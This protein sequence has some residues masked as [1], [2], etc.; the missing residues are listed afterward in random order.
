MAIGGAGEAPAWGRFRSFAEHALRLGYADLAA[1]AILA[2]VAA[3]GYGIAVG[4]GARVVGG[5][6]LGVLATAGV[7]AARG[8]RHE[9][10]RV[11][12]ELH[13]AEARSAAFEAAEAAL[14]QAKSAAEAA[15][16][17]KSEFLANVSHEI[18]TPMN[19]IIGMTELALDTD[20][21]T[22]QREYLDM[23]RSSADALLTVI[24]DILDF[25][26]IEAGKL[27]LCPSEF[28]L[29]RSLDETMRP[30]ALRARQK[31]LAC[32]WTIAPD[33]PPVLVADAGRLRQV[34]LNLVGNAIKFTEAGGRVAVE[35]ARF[36]CTAPPDLDDATD[37]LDLH[38]TVSDTGI[39]IA[40]EQQRLIFEAFAQA[41]GSMA[42]RYGGTGLG[43]TIASQI[44]AL[45]GGRLWVDS[46]LGRGSRFQFTIRCRRPA[47][48]PE[49][50]RELEYLRGLPVLVVDDTPINRRVLEQTLRQWSME[51]TCVADAE[52]ALAQLE[53]ARSN[54]TPY[55][56]ALLDV[57]MPEQDGFALVENIRRRPYLNGVTIM[58]LSSSDLQGAAER[59]RSLGVAA[60][61]RKPIKRSDLLD[62]LLVTLGLRNSS[63]PVNS[64]VP[65]A[66]PA[67]APPPAV[68]ARSSRPLHVLVAEDNTVNQRLACRLLE[69]QGHT[70]VLADTG[71]AAL[72]ALDRDRF[73]LILMDVQMPEMDGLEATGEIRRRERDGGRSGQAAPPNSRIPIVA[74]TAHAMKGDAER[75]LDAGM[76]AYVSKPVQPTTLFAVIERVVP[77]AADTAAPIAAHH[78]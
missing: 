70:V 61:L 26:K 19:G 72:D 73:D 27:D 62:A 32:A 64:S 74:M 3:A 6:T 14:Q 31:G 55:S 38:V 41:D 66:T 1:P 22:E 48:T 40:P 42:R 60:W 7:L 39:G 46:A 59:A 76:D 58:M 44:V 71:R 63:Y 52:S 11:A 13:R 29:A 23:V 24:N 36:T 34:L 65:A 50:P 67:A 9:G 49:V 54:G 37:G 28:T 68:P 4:G 35:V 57:Q 15:N 78:R 5:L 21:S 33:V 8:L 20:L 69:R 45:M 25:A 77:G 2:L 43:L 17:A 10:E 16:R 12:R 30:L 51:P 53:V 56:L 75:C 18:R 47:V